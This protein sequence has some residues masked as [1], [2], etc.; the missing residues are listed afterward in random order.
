MKNSSISTNKD[1]Q[2]HILKNG[3]PIPIFSKLAKNIF[4]KNQVF[5]S[6]LFSRKFKS[7][8]GVSIEVCSCTWYL[9]KT[10]N[11]TD[12]KPHHLLWALFF[13]ENL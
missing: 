5:L 6:T 12:A 9:L 1:D 11:E 4:R 7:H 2:C 13:F 10:G 8:F 3:K